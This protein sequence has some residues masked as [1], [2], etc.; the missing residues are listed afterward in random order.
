MLPVEKQ[1]GKFLLRTCHSVA[2]MRAALQLQRV[3]WNFSDE[4][5]VPVRLFVVG[6]KVG[7][8]VLGAFD[9]DRMVGFA[10]G[11]PS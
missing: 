7:G 1:F 10:Y 8:H 11:I 3:V 6:E 2:D 4:E 9:G 5:L